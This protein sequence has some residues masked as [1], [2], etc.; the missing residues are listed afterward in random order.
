MPIF[1]VCHSKIFNEHTSIIYHPKWNTEHFSHP[2]KF[3][4][5]LSS[6]INSFVNVSVWREA[7]L[8]LMFV[9]AIAAKDL[10]IITLV[11]EVICFFP[12]SYCLWVTLITS[13]LM[14]VV[15]KSMVEGKHSINLWLTLSLLVVWI[16]GLYYSKMIF[17]IIT[18][19]FR[20]DRKARG[21]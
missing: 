10:V 6:N 19:Y 20:W 13:T 17:S 1:S 2:R 18:S 4:A 21:H 5:A 3:H 16:P 15:V 8:W 7:G 12:F 11:L 14:V 9:V